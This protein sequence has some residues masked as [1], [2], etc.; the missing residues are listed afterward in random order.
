MFAE[1]RLDL[2]Q[3]GADGKNYD[4]SEWFIAPRKAINQAITMIESGEILN[5]RYDAN[6]ERFVEG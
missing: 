6:E 1:V 5:V 2:T 3:V 4:P